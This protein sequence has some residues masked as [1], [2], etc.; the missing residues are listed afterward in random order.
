M[1]MEKVII[2]NM[3]NY[4]LRFF[5]KYTIE[6]ISLKLIENHK[7]H[8]EHNDELFSLLMNDIEIKM[9]QRDL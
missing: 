8:I 4:S 6:Y 2:L 9:N 5:F 3:L 7:Q 1:L